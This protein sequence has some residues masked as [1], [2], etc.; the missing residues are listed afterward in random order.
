MRNSQ[1]R[2]TGIQQVEQTEVTGYSQEATFSYVVPTHLVDIPSKGDY[3]PV[4]HP[5]FSKDS[6]E[7]REMTAK[8]EDILFNKSY[9]EKGIVIDKLLQ[10]I[11]VDKSINIDS[12][13]IIDKNALLVAA[14]LLGYGKEYGILAECTQCGSKFEAEIDI[15]NLLNIEEA[16][17]P[18]EATKLQNGLV[19]LS[20]PV[21]KWKVQVKLLNGNDQNTLQKIFEKKKKNNLEQNAV[22]ESLRSFTHAINGNTDSSV[23]YNSLSNMPAKDSK[24]L[25]TTY[26]NCFPNVKSTAPIT[27][28][29]CDHTEEME[30]PFNANF[31]WSK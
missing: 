7:I 4:G 1:E 19:E 28:T 11:I 18:E 17:P 13:Y 16:K 12:L 9:I 6:I 20:L 23:I 8:E 30:V 15:T 27:C 29:V 25:R 31:F 5:L 14:R 10:S 3:Y 22:I 2:L 21:T 24:F 26:Q